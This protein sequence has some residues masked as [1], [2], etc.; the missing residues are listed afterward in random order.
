MRKSLKIMIA[1]ML[2]AGVM[3]MGMN[4]EAAVQDGNFLLIQHNVLLYGWVS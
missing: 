1:S 3:T 4:A 2:C